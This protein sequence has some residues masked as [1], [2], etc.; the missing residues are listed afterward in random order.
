M[1]FFEDFK[2]KDGLNVHLWQTRKFKSVHL[3]IY[4]HNQLSDETT[5]FNNLLGAVLTRGTSEYPETRQFSKSLDMLY[6]ASVSYSVSRRGERGLLSLSAVMADVEIEGLSPIKVLSRLLASVLFGPALDA[7]GLLR[8][9][10]TAQERSGIAND[11]ASLRDDKDAWADFRCSAN[12]CSEEPFGIHPLGDEGLLKSIGPEP[13]TSW[14]SGVLPSCPADIFAVGDF[15]II[16]AL[17]EIRRAFA[18]S[19]KCDANPGNP[20]GQ[21]IVPTSGRRF[22]EYADTQQAKLVIG[23]RSPIRWSDR[24]YPAHAMANHIF[25]QYS[26]SKLFMNVREKEGMAYS[27]GSR[28]EPTKGLV[29]AY[30]GVDSGN[31]EKAIDVILKEHASLCSGDIT[32]K[33]LA[34]AKKSMSL[35]IRMSADKPGSLCGREVTGIVNSGRFTI[36]EAVERIN[37]VRAEEIA[38]AA[39]SWALDTVFCLMPETSGKEA[40]RR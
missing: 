12:M 1:V 29:F 9:D 3:Q 16:E 23:W 26:Q 35:G 5:T 20:F 30:A 31:M 17:E 22:I 40:G 36:E 27:V 2:I 39:S 34:D 19:L 4:L 13:L 7:G 25:G 32:E 24:D 14:W 11:I 6:G 21:A 10:Y 33:E 28:L 18:G 8:A 37:A 38:K 15:D